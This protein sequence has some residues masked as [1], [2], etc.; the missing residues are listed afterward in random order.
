MSIDS[1][2]FERLPLEQKLALLQA[3]HAKASD[4]AIMAE[5]FR[6]RRRSEVRAEKLQAQ[7]DELIARGQ[8]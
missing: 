6:I 1:P 4:H 3:E 5:E 2:D 8:P 7:M